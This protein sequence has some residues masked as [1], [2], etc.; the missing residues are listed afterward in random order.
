MIPRANRLQR[1][2]RKGSATPI[3]AIYVGRPTIWGNPFTIDRWGHARCVVLHRRWLTGAIAALTLEGMGFCPAEIDA[4]DRKRIAILTR[5]HTLAGRDLVCWCP[6]S[7]PWCHAETYLDLAP[8][9]AELER[10]AA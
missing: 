8:Q 4:L 6:L 3:G 10:L 7:S 5:L 2:R 1:S 9:Y